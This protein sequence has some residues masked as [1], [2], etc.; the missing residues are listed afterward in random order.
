M[1]LMNKDEFEHITDCLLD[2]SCRTTMQEM[3]GICSY[4]ELISRIQNPLFSEKLIKEMVDC[5]N[6]LSTTNPYAKGGS[7]YR[8]ERK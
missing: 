5:L 1:S 2:T 6:T 3:E 7:E 8:D 4:E